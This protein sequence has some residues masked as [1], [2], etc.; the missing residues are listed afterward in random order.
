[1]ADNNRTPQKKVPTT[2]PERD[3]AHD[4]PSAEPAGH[5]DSLDSDPAH[6]EREWGGDQ[7]IDTA[8]QVPDNKATDD[9]EPVG[10]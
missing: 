7:D 3:G 4:E 8:G 2:P 5:G 1:M 6:S 9:K 10:F